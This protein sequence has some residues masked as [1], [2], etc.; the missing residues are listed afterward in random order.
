MNFGHFFSGTDWTWVVHTFSHHILYIYLPI[1]HNWCLYQSIWALKMWNNCQNY[2][3]SKFWPF[4]WFFGHFCSGTDQKWVVHTFSYPI[5]YICMYLFHNWCLYQ[6][7]WAPRC[8]IMAKTIKINQFWPFWPF[9]GDFCSGTNQTGV[10][11]TFLH[12]ILY[13]FTF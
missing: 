8:E 4:L 9:L 6:S 5:L 10:V 3:N 13:I 2:K 11:H 7:I 1:F 12:H